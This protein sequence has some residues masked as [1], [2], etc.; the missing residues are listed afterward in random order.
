M[1]LVVGVDLGG[2][3]VRAAIADARGEILAVDEVRTA[4]AGAGLAAAVAA[5]EGRLVAQVGAAA[6][7]VAVT[8]V[9]GAGVVT[10]DGFTDAPHLDATAAA[11]LGGDLAVLVGHPVALE[12]DVNV[13]ALGALHAREAGESFAFV[14][15]GTG[16]GMGLVIDG[17]IVRGARGAAGEIGYLPMGADPTDP[18]N[19]RRGALE[20]VAA[21]E[22]VAQRYADLAGVE[23]D[24]AEVFAAAAR[25][26]AGAEAAVDAYARWVAHAVGAVI[27]VV[28]PALILLGGG[29]GSREDLAPRVRDWLAALGF[30]D[31]EV[32]ASALGGRGPLLGAV[33]LA[34]STSSPEPAR[35][36]ALT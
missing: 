11:T 12:N 25:G 13:A 17:R 15:L 35:A 1:T 9:G 4:D 24:T 3:K 2:T 29:I 7:D 28:D 19:H 8:A 10:G 31:T 14:S 33:R 30:V 18:D 16:I 27:A 32:R 26:D 6:A 36:S 20:E 21:G 23:L 34:L 5:L 22:T